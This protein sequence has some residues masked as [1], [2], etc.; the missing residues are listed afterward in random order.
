[1]VPWKFFGFLKDNRWPN[2]VKKKTKIW[3]EKRKGR[4]NRMTLYGYIWICFRA[5]C[6]IFTYRYVH[7]ASHVLWFSRSSI[8]YCIFVLTFVWNRISCI[9][10]RNFYRNPSYSSTHGVSSILGWQHGWRSNHSITSYVLQFFSFSSLQIHHRV[11][12]V[13]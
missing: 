12:N 9:M 10:R 8:L 13:I 3:L 2:T 6:M 4:W 7:L 1:M 11:K 5:S